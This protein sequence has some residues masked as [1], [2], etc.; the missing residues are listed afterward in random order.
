MVQYE[1]L[2]SLLLNILPRPFDDELR[3]TG[4]V[5]PTAYDDITV[6]F[7]D[8]VG[9]TLSSERIPPNDLVDGLHRYFSTFDEIVSR[10]GLE[11]MKT[12]GDSYMFVGGLPERKPS[13]AVDAV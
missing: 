2:E 6:C 11:K 12:I 4:A 9:F 8:F 1:K 3:S 10:Y 7:T 5:T 13:H